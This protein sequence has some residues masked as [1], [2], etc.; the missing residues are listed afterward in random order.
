MFTKKL[1]LALLGLFLSFGYF[2]YTQT[3]AIPKGINC[4]DAILPNPASYFLGNKTDPSY[5]SVQPFSFYS[6]IFDIKFEGALAV[7]K[8][9]PER[10]ILMG[11]IISSSD[12]CLLAESFASITFGQ[13]GPDQDNYVIVGHHKSNCEGRN[14]PLSN[15]KTK[16]KRVAGSLN[17]IPVNSDLFLRM[18]KDP[19]SGIFVDVGPE[20]AFL[21]I[22]DRES[23]D[24]LINLTRCA[25]EML[26]NE[27]DLHKSAFIKTKIDMPKAK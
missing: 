12:I 3:K 19:V 1:L 5:I 2:Y 16:P 15:Q 8:S 18:L 26:G 13:K 9:S 10:I 27:S 22:S 17:S 23:S 21:P 7:S 24:N 6:D 14:T 11:D 4:A 25:Y 20:V